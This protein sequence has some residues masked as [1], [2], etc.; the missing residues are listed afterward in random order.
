MIN[1]AVM[2]DFEKE[3]WTYASSALLSIYAKQFAR[4]EKG[5]VS[6]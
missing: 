2:L 5:M 1:L 6:L 3:R 4:F